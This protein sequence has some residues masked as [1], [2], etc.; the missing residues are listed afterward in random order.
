M[1]FTRF[2]CSNISFSQAEK[3]DPLPRPLKLGE[4]P[5]EARSFLWSR[6]FRWLSQSSE[7]D[8]MGGGTF[9]IREARTILRDFH[10]SFLYRPIDEYST[11]FEENRRFVKEY[12]LSQ[13]FN[14]V[15]D[16]LQ[17]VMRQR[18][19]PPGF[20]DLVKEILEKFMCAYTVIADGPSI[21]P[22]S[23]PEQQESIQKSF[24]LLLSTPFDGAREHLKK[25]ARLINDGQPSDS[26]RESIHAVES[27][28][29]RLNSNSSKSLTL[30]LNALFKRNIAL[31]PALEK[32]IKNFYGYTSDEEGIRH[33]Q[34][35]NNTNVQIEDA[36]FMYSACASFCSYLVEKARKAKLI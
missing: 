13:P 32:G 17:F 33:A 36:V 3:L 21:V 9:V 28:A 25:A 35:G 29:R 19:A 23:I 24:E 14:K 16:F 10:A 11:D 12:V 22:A 20:K 7:S 8:V 4:L 2:S 34:M 15:F 31:H 1:N 6:I 30:A 18:K 27:I 5:R 26:I